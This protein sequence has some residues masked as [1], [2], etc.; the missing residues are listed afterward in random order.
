MIE[1]RHP[2]ERVSQRTEAK[3]D[4]EHSFTVASRGVYGRAHDFVLH[5][6]TQRVARAVDFGRHRHQQ[7]RAFAGVHHL[8]RASGAGC[9]QPLLT[10]DAAKL[11]VEEGSFKVNA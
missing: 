4:G 9:E 6:N 2:V 5:E 7:T 1:W 11:G 10:M 8:P 3:S